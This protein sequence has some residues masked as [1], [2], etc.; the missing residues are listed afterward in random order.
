MGGTQLIARTPLFR[1]IGN[2]AAENVL[3][4]Q[5]ITGQSAKRNM[6]GNDAAAIG[7]DAEF[8]LRSGA[9]PIEYVGPVRCRYESPRGAADHSLRHGFNELS[10]TPSAVQDVAAARKREGAFLHFLD[11]KAV[12]LI[13]RFQRVNPRLAVG[14]G[15]DDGID[16]SIADRIEGLLRFAQ[17][18]PKRV[19]LPAQRRLRVI[20]G[21]GTGGSGRP[22]RVHLPI[23]VP[24]TGMRSR[25]ARIRSS[26]ARSPMIRR[27]GRGSIFTKVG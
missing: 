26:L 6:S 11:E 25:P 7:F 12:G 5:V 13:R 3:A 10:E 24:F 2:D 20:L 18:L 23:V 14:T 15:D 22:S 8:G 17:L 19:V 4:P 9:D 16:I 27:N 21:R 1:Q